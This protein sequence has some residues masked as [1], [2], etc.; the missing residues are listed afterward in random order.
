[1]VEYNRNNDG[2]AEIDYNLSKFYVQLSF[3]SWCGYFFSFFF[4]CSCMEDGSNNHCWE[5]ILSRLEK[6]QRGNKWS[7][8][9]KK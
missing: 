7:I 3:V 4:F 9:P 1:M 8:D 2:D 6:A 5:E